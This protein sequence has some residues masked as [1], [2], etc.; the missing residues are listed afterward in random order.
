MIGDTNHAAGFAHAADFLRTL[1]R[2]R[3]RAL[4]E[5][6]MP[7]L[8]Q[9]HAPDYQLITPPGMPFTRE[10]YLGLLE[11]G[12]LRYLRWDAGEMAVRCSERMAIVRYPVTLEL[13]GGMSP[14]MPFPCWHTDSYELNGTQW[15]A[16]W[17]QA[18][19]LRQPA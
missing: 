12:E 16:T 15:Q 17:S 6:D 8:R 5:R 19:A 9:L 3:I 11:S 2:A 18:T 4:L 7:L 1:E 14:G 13:A 10:R